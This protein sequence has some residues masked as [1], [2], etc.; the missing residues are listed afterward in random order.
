MAFGNSTDVIVYVCAGG[1][2]DCQ[3]GTAKIMSGRPKEDVPHISRCLR[4]SL[5]KM[6]KEAFLVFSL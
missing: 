5:S 3:R 4:C 6:L 2:F 1:T